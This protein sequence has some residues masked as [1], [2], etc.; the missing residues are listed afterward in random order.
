MAQN[1]AGEI[2]QRPR[3][4]VN[5]FSG[6][7]ITGLWYNKEENFK[8]SKPL[9][10]EY[11]FLENLRTTFWTKSA[12][13]RQIACPIFVDIFSTS[14]YIKTKI[15][16]TVYDGFQIPWNSCKHSKYHFGTLVPEILNKICNYCFL[17]FL[18]SV[19]CV[20]DRM[21]RVRVQTVTKRR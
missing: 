5:L 2:T 20:L 13:V 21:A 16:H 7:R 1:L 15:L 9:Q 14:R 6:L 18:K 8:S 11:I 12:K 10:S 3:Y 19:K 17:R 4:R